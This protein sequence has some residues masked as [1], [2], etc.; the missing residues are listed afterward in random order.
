MTLS[1][2]R[3]GARAAAAA[4][5]VT[6]GAAHAA[7]DLGSIRLY[8]YL[9]RAMLVESGVVLEA[10]LDTG[11]DN[12]SVH[13]PDWAFFERD[14][15]RWVRFSIEG[16]KGRSATYERKVLR[17]ARIQ[18][19]KGKNA[20]RP[21]VRMRL[22]V[23]DVEAAVEVNLADRSDLEFPMLIGRSFLEKGVLVNSFAEWTTEPTCVRELAR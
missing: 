15:E 18:Q 21:V 13:A 4:L 3:G 1:H 20:E 11:A 17:I 22:C 9:E 8:G 19:R 5:A 6:S 16:E 23:G 2:L 14:G 10:K 7:T 12:S